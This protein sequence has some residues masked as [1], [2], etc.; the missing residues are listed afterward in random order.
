M[1]ALMYIK[2]RDK[3]SSLE[4]I[5]FD[6]VNSPCVAMS[7]TFTLGSLEPNCSHDKALCTFQPSFS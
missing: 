3:L 2:K 4:L 6:Y 5:G 7:K 1:E